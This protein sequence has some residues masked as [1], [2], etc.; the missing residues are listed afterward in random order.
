[1]SAESLL[2][3]ARA[4]E[5]ERA[6]SCERELGPEHAIAVLLSTAFPPLKPALGWQMDALDE[7]ARAGWRGRRQR[8]DLLGRLSTAV[9]DFSDPDAVRSRLRR[10]VWTEK[11]R[12]ALRE[13]LP[14][15]QGGASIDVTA[16]ELSDLAEAALEIA[17]AEARAHVVARFG[18]PRLESGESAQIVCLGMGKLGGHELNAGS[19]VDLIFVY[20]SDDGAAGELALHDFWTRVV[21]RAVVTIEA[22]TADGLV[23]RV[24]LRLRPEGSQ[25]PIAN[26][27]AASERYYETWGRLWERAAMLRAR[28]VAGDASLGRV[29]EREL[30]AP[31]V[32]RREL[33][34]AI[35]GALSQLVEQSRAELSKN[36]ARD[37]KLGP[38]GI[39]EAEFFVQSLQLF[40]GGRE[41]SLRVT[42]T[43][44]AL[45]RLRARGLVSDREMRSVAGA[46][47]L[48][49]RVEHR[50]Q[51]MSGVQTHDLPEQESELEVLARSLEHADARALLDELGAVRARVAK[52][53]RSLS[54]GGA[55]KL[56][57][58]HVLIQKLDAADPTLSEV[59]EQTFGNAEVAE[60]LRALGRRPDGLL[61]TLTRERH[62]ELADQVLDGIAESPDPEQAART[63]RSLLGRFPSPGAYVTLLSEDPRA[64]A[65]LLWVVGASAFVGDAVVSRPEL[66]E[67]VLFGRDGV[68]EPRKVM[69]AELAAAE[70]ASGDDLFERR[71]A[72]VQATRRAKRRVMVEVAVADLA[73]VLTTRDATRLLSDLADETVD[74]AVRFEL[75]GSPRGLAVI[76]VG[77]LGGREIGYGSDLDVLFVFDPAAAPPDKDA[78]EHFV[79]VAHRIIRLISEAHPAGP[80]YELDTRL[81]PSGSHGMLVTSLA[82]FSRYHGDQLGA[83]D[84]GPAVQ[85]SGAAWE[86]QALI[87]A[88]GAAGDPELVGAVMRVATRAA[89]EAGAPP[90]EEMHRLRLRMEVELG[91]E[92]D[93]RY[94]LKSGRGGLLDIEFLTQWLQMRYGTDPRVRSPDTAEGLEAL[95]SLG[96]LPRPEFETLRE[97]Y[98]F[99][100]RLEQRIHVLH[101]TSATVLDVRAPGLAQLARRMGLHDGARRSGVEELLERYRDVTEAVRAAY[102]RVLSIRG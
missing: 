86:R 32:F 66:G 2:S 83:D 97:A 100:R 64:L 37:V 19:D 95:A 34:P 31:F 85:S 88:R 87:R 35:A 28:P 58:H 77:K 91:R 76:A 69:A 47:R 30:I 11:A 29:V 22:P 16:A 39:R 21:R 53:F 81:R 41:P 82:S 57:R 33:D 74:R 44:P 42:G 50:V 6:R 102:E 65:R 20:D 59:A 71:D 61:G 98:A 49:R 90:V 60:H 68:P 7:I 3:R 40:W 99:L 43:L 101:A 36:P 25:G 52:L 8:A 15:S 14:P 18:E 4:I 27:V 75:G 63:L 45:N 93:G 56:A 5:P 10:A 51:W 84:A 13:L 73:G 23:W 79:R 78:G 55:P 94:D 67:V 1:M 12:I 38:G 46:Y 24:D 92:R 62:P 80:G 26:S 96:Y 89:Y 9:A 72:F 17:L 70:A 48:L 54:P